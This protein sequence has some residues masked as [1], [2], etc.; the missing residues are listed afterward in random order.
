MQARREAGEV[1]MAERPEKSF[2]ALF[3]EL[4]GQSAGLVRD[5]ITLV[6]HEI[7]EKAIQTK[8]AVIFLSLG[9]LL[10]LLALMTLSA[11]AILALAPLVGAWQAALIVGGIFL[12]LGGIILLLGKS[13][14][15]ASTLKP[16]QTI[17]TMEE[18]KEWLKEIT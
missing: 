3:A 15:S 11:A 6:R 8:A 9:A 4:A 16:E 13:R 17:E 14:L 5:E 18:N 10:C 7:K 1:G 2:G 12:L